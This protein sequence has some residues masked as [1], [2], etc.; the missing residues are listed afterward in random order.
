[1]DVYAHIVVRCLDIDTGRAFGR[2]ILYIISE[3]V[4]D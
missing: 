4:S 2:C 3:I 1:M